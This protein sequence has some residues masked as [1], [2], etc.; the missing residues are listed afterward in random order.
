MQFVERIA[1]LFGWLPIQRRGDESTSRNAGA[2]Y[3]LISKAESP[4]IGGGKVCSRPNT[5][6]RRVGEPTSPPHPPVPLV[7][8]PGRTGLGSKQSLPQSLRFLRGRAR[9]IFHAPVGTYRPGA[10]RCIA[11]VHC[12]AAALQAAIRAS[13]FVRWKFL[14]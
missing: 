10:A 5:C 9:S 13:G 6:H 7:A 14:I 3:G 2:L 1:G 11:R 12:Y 8:A 4:D